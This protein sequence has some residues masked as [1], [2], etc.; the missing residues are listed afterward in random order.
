MTHHLNDSDG[1]KPPN[2][3]AKL[4]AVTTALSSHK[5]SSKGP[6]GGVTLLRTGCGTSAFVASLTRHF[7][8]AG[9]QERK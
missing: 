3:T 5:N 2:Q 4:V 7:F 8:S 9:E 6:H 1:A